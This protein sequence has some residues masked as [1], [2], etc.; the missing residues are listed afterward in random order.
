MRKLSIF[1]IFL[2]WYSNWTQWK[3]SF[4]TT[5]VG[6]VEK[7]LWNY[8]QTDCAVSTVHCALY[9]FVKHEIGFHYLWFVLRLIQIMNK[10]AASCGS[11][12]ICIINNINSPIL[13]FFF[14]FPLL[15][16]SNPNAIK[17]IYNLLL[18]VCVYIL[19]TARL[20]YNF[21]FL[22]YIFG[23]EPF[24]CVWICF[25]LVFRYDS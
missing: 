24:V 25:S 9:R 14:S 13:L 22:F 1:I 7:L 20:Q 5:T 2:I 15:Q 12:L 6:F 10:C 11:T 4:S 19:I 18:C 16:Q 23:S 17:F 21:F 3:Y 8:V